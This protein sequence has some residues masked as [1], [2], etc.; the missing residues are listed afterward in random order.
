MNKKVRFFAEQVLIVFN[1]FI[2]FLLLFE[3]KLVVPAW[4]QPVGRMH[5]LILHFPI[6]LL[7]LSIAMQWL[8]SS[9]SLRTNH[10]YGQLTRILLLSGIL[11]AGITVVMGLF[12]SKEEG[13][14]GNTLQWH[15]WTGAFIF[16]FASILYGIGNKR[17]YKGVV[18][19]SSGLLVV[20]ALI[21]TGHYGANLTH[22][23]DFI[24][25]PLAVYKTQ[26]VVPIDQAMVFEHVIQP[27]F[28]SKCINCHNAEKLKGELMLIDSASIVKGGKTGKLFVPGNP[29]LSLLLERVHLP[30]E[31]KKHMPPKGKAQL[32]EAEITLLALWIK[33]ETPF[34]QKV[35]AFP[36]D[37]SL[38]LMATALLQPTK[39]EEERYTFSAADEQTIAQLNTDYRT[40]APLAKESPALA[41]N[42]YNREAY[43]P[44]QLEEL[45]P[46]KKQVVAL[47]LNK[48]PVKDNDLKTIAQFENLRKLD[49]NFTD[50]SAKGLQVLGSLSNL[51]TLAVSGT[52]VSYKELAALIP[53]FKRLA[54][55]S[56]WETQ[57]TPGE[58][59]ELQK[60]YPAVNFIKGFSDDGTNPL[61]LNPPQI[62]NSSVIFDEPLALQLMHP[63]KDV[64][65]HYT[66]DGSE[67]DSIHAPLFDNTTL[68]KESTTIKAKAYKQGWFAS[69]VVEF[70]FFKNTYKPDSV[71]L[72]L[73]LNSVHQAEG[74]ETFFNTRLGV[75]GAN[76]PAW[77]NNWAG[78]RNNDMVLVS[79]FKQPIVLSSVGLHYMV[80]EATGILPPASVEVW[81]GDSEHRLKLLVKMK[82][83]L[84]AK[85]EMPSLK[86]VEESFKPQ[87]ISYLKIVAKPYM[88][89]DKRR[90][91]LVDEMFLN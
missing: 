86:K 13:Y 74:A 75:I 41:V 22:G 15:K 76:N 2:A 50:I 38:R 19:T 7:I 55:V 12:L 63:I 46:I 18:A 25:Q 91:L 28:E 72:L 45:M 79:E 36:A 73:P 17:W 57:I 14:S 32:T 27:I 66:V 9:P 83:P 89:K 49:L 10:F 39:P 77:A 44:K 43:T 35:M 84:P 59:G 80:E 81:G 47:N 33:A 29:G 1:I 52:S 37:D 11:S 65:I 53:S 26:P 67:P 71:R 24:L 34:T 40:I 56:V 31:E 70:D 3:S 87:T 23:E 54:T 69:D 8:R 5:P 78:V 90:L 62:Q 21:V 16:F 58:A 42:I 60:K 48:L 64:Q 85:G 68:L 6:V 88:E 4:L 51:Q 20:A 82:P 61:K 30:L